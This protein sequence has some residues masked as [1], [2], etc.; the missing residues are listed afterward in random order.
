MAAPLWLLGG[1]KSRGCILP[2]L[3]RVCTVLKDK[4]AAAPCRGVG[5]KL[6]NVAGEGGILVKES[7]GALQCPLDSKAL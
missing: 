6:S 4:G 7:A 2:G 1:A 3:P 5:A